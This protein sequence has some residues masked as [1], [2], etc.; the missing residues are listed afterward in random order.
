MYGF[1]EWRSLALW[2]AYPMLLLQQIWFSD[3]IIYTYS[4]KTISL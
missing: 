4:T 3:T 2:V 1:I